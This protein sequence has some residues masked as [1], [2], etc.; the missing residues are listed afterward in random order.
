M[1]A[2]RYVGIVPLAQNSLAGA[3]CQWNIEGWL[4]RRVDS[5]QAIDS[6][7]KIDSTI[8]IESPLRIDFTLRIDSTPRI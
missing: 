5:N 7:L 4:N 2:L 3:S 1:E 8:R 6:T